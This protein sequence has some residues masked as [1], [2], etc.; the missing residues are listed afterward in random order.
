[1]S[2]SGELRYPRLQDVFK[3]KP[4]TARKYL[5]AISC[6]IALLPEI[7]DAAEIKVMTDTPVASVLAR[8]G[9]VFHRDTGNQVKLVFGLSPAIEK[10]IADGEAADV[11]VIQPN[12]VNN[13][14]DSGKIVG[15]QFPTIARVGIGLFARA[16]GNT[17]DVSTVATFKQALLDAD[18]LVFS[19]VAA[20]N[21][22]ATVLERLGIADA[23][24]DKVVRANPTDVIARI[25]ESK[26]ND[27]GVISMTLLVADKRLRLVGALPAEYQSYLYY[28]AASMVASQSPDAAKEFVQFLTSPA[29]K[30]EFA[31]AGAN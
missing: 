18:M 13:L 19:N 21:Y 17:P 5:I 24:K 22:F 31:A 4:M 25:V 12:F 29:A 3:G 30:K 26:G 20:G 23:V 14:V 11:V 2:G 16:D 8:I 15:G 27:I 10:K 6:I 28:T 1:M 9:D 7:A